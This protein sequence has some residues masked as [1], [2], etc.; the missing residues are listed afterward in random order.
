MRCQGC[1]FRSAASSG[2]GG[3][4]VD[5]PRRLMI[6]T[7]IGFVCGFAIQTFALKTRLYDAV[8]DGK[9]RRRIETDEAILDL[10]GDIA[11]W[12]AEDMKRA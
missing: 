11:K 5:L 6:M 8:S 2:A 9:L 10:R 4:R 1:C 7:S 12:Q 3:G